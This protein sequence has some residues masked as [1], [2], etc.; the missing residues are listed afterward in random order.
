MTLE[1][2]R[3][4]ISGIA[5]IVAYV[6]YVVV[7]L[8]RADGGPIA[9]VSYV[10]PLLWTVAGAIGVSIAGHIGAGFRTPAEDRVTDVR[11]RD[12]ARLGERV[13]AAFVV[14][15]AL[16]ALVLAM[17]K[18][19]H[20]WIANAVYLGFVLSGLLDAATRVLTYRWGS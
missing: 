10:A 20:F 1:Q 16:A 17:V 18:A 2:K 4:W 9:E 13:G 8:V 14:L 6:I 19:P 12:I 7:V 5:T 11:D 3:A 15:G